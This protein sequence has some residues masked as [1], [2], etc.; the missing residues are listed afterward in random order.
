MT[1]N[2]IWI[3]PDADQLVGYMARV[4]NSAA[5]PE[6]DSTKLISYLLSH[7]HWSPLE[8]VSAC[9]EIRTT[10]DI[11]RQILRHRSFHFQEFSQRY[12]EVEQTKPPL[13]EARLQDPKNRQNSLS[14]NLNDPKD[15]DT[16][17]KWNDLQ[18]VVWNNS[19]LLYNSALELGIAKEQARALLPEGLT[20]TKM[21]MS[22]TLRDWL[23]YLETR[24]DA[25][26]QREHRMVAKEIL[27]LLTGA[28]PTI[29]LSA[30]QGG[31]AFGAEPTG[32]D[33]ANH[34]RKD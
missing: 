11:A 26:T 3:T 27:G 19:Y 22:G 14:L 30:K 34:D 13:R 25:G 5:R 2:L 20:E 24:L 31:F 10:R 21:Y 29:I 17:N 4:S 18:E 6:D 15:Y 8:M 23:F 33:Q 1:A 9:V 28:C 7:K 12:A 16:S 32:E